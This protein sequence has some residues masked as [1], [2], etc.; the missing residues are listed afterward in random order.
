MLGKIVPE[1]KPSSGAKTIFGRPS[2]VYINIKNIP[3]QIE[4]QTP[5]PPCSF[6]ILA[7][8]STASS[9]SP[10]PESTAVGA[11]PRTTIT[12]TS[13]PKQQS[14]PVSNPSHEPSLT[15]LWVDCGKSYADAETLYNHLCNDHIGRKSTNNLCLTCKWK[16]CGATCAKRDHITSHL[17]G[18]R[19]FEVID[20]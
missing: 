8:M 4:K 7:T 9:S 13:S 18:N 1:R 14:S 16:D 6:H 2:S 15:C 11:T 5:F 12:E 3:R 10:P 19:S 20:I 17:R